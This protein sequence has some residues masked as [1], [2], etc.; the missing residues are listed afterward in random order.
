MVF[1]PATRVASSGHW[2]PTASYPDP[3]DWCNP[4]GRGLGVRPTSNT[5]NALIDTFLWG[6]IPGASDGEC[7]RGLGPGGTTVD[8]EWGIIDPGAGD[9]FPA[10]ALDLVYNANPPLEV[11]DD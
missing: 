9:W 3:Q 11:E 4:P 5:G 10:M 7:T 1:A 6:K 8:P 2:T